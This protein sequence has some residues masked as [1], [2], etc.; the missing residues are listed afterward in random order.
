MAEI[1]PSPEIAIK[2][3]KNPRHAE[4]FIVGCPYAENQRR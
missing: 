2:N 3:Q 1:L 4:A